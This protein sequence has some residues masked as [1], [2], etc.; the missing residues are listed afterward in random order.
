MKLD[1]SLNSKSLSI[2]DFENG[3]TF[4]H[5]PLTIEQSVQGLLFYDSMIIGHLLICVNYGI[6]GIG[7][8]LLTLSR[9]AFRNAVP[10]VSLQFGMEI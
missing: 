4:L 9:G 2:A 1:V 8:R 3:T 7:Q 5:E 6:D 10:G